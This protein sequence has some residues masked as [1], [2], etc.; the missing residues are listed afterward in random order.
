MI[1]KRKL[2]RAFK[3]NNRQGYSQFNEL[4]KQAWS[5]DL[6]RKNHV[7]HGRIAYEKKKR[8]L[9]KGYCYDMDTLERVGICDRDRC[10][11]ID[12]TTVCRYK[13][14]PCDMRTASIIEN[15]G[16]ILKIKNMGLYDEKKPL[17]FW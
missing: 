13:I 11:L 2:L 10:Y 15:E 6:V 7:K 8:R 4:Q 12:H 17:K 1:K 16:S 9:G 14:H 5:H 3:K